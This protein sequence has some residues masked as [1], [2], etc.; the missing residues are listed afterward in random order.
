MI[1]ST[2]VGMSSISIV[3][4]AGNSNVSYVKWD[5]VIIRVD[6]TF[7]Y[8]TKIQTPLK[9]IVLGRDGGQTE[10]TSQYLCYVPPY[11]TIPPDFPTF[12]INSSHARYFKLEQKFIGETGC[13]ISI[14][15]PVI[16]LIPAPD[17][18]RCSRCGEW[19]DGVEAPD[20]EYF[21]CW[22]CRT[23]PYR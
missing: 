4:G 20:F 12:T 11:E 2:N 10:S 5:E 3:A 15:T 14:W 21:T 16:K 19:F 7:G 9:V 17:G 23:N 6:T 13:F 18:E 8:T 1:V 22:S